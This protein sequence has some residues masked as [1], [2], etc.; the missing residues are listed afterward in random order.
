MLPG[1]VNAFDWSMPLLAVKVLET[2]DHVL[3]SR[4]IEQN[5]QQRQEPVQE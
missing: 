4:Y 3:L 5:Q 2:L 1:F